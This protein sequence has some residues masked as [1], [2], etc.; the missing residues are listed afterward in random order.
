VESRPRPSESFVLRFARLTSG[1]PKRRVDLELR[2]LDVVFALVF[3]LLVLPIVLLIAAA[4]ALTSGLPVLYRG[5]RVGRGGRI[6]TIVKFRTLKRDAEVRLGPF[7]GEELVRRTRVEYTPVG[8]RLR[9][10]QLDELP[11]LW[12]VLR[13][14]MS[15]VGPR[16][17]RP[18][19]FEQLAGELAAYWQRLVVRPGLTGFAQVRGAYEASMAE[20]L[21]HD[22]EWIAD[23]SVRLYLRTLF[24]TAW[25]VARQSLGLH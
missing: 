7:L 12:N 24:A 4:S 15:F 5:E 14:D 11:Q 19:F 20:K 18:R 2:I 21:A 25:R 22:L 10:S 13:G 17:I 23:R 3:G 16:P 9:A 8:R 6:F 1:S